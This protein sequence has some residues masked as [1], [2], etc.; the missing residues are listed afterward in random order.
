[1]LYCEVQAGKNIKSNAR[2]T[3]VERGIIMAVS[4]T[5]AVVKCPHC[6]KLLPL[7]P[8][9]CCTLCEKSVQD[10]EW[11]IIIITEWKQNGDPYEPHAGVVLNLEPAAV[12]RFIQAY[13]I[14]HW[15]HLPKELFAPGALHS[16]PKPP[17]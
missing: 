9:G 10:S 6:K 2:K 8:H 13:R 16:P 14:G 4:P 11:E 1:M 3:L 12:A 5:L 7:P 17:S 15:V